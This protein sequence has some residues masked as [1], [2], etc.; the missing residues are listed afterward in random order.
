ML[1]P[2]VGSPVQRFT[3]SNLT[4]K[5]G[6]ILKRLV[7]KYP[8]RDERGWANQLRFMCDRNDC[9][10]IVQLHGVALA[11]VVQT[12]TLVGKRVVQERFVW[13]E[14]RQNPDQV[15]AAAD[16]YDEFHRWAF[17]LGIDEIVIAKDTDVPNEMIQSRLG[18]I[19]L[20]QTR[21]VKV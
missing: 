21:F 1:A 13:C 7:A 18:K 4:D 16:F 6:W 15:E 12:D 17:S 14:D 9:L 11:E 2:I 20:S 19:Y 3:Q 10:F 5:A 8:N